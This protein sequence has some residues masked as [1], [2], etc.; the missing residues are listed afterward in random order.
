MSPDD[1]AAPPP[2][3]ILVV[4]PAV[5]AGALLTIPD[6]E[7]E[8]LRL[9]DGR[10]TVAEV[11]AGSGLGRGG[12]VRLAGAP[13]RRRRAAGGP[14]G[15]RGEGGGP[16]RAGGGR[17]VR[18]SGL[19]AR[20]RTPART[21]GRAPAEAPPRVAPPAPAPTVDGR[22]RS[23]GRLAVAAVALGA[24]VVAGAIWAQRQRGSAPPQ[25]RVE[26]PAPET[27]PPALA[28]TEPSPGTAYRDALLEVGVRQRG[29]RSRG[30]GGG[31]PPGHRDRS[32]GRGRLAGARR[33]LAGGR[34]SGPRP[35]RLRALPGRRTRWTARPAGP[36]AAR[37]LA[38][39]TP[40]GT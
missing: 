13:P 6:G 14:P 20:A 36:G 3:A 12:R 8:I 9:A 4:D 27:P 31:L 22:G 26:R 40:G 38:P 30:R 18:P 5:L 19:G 10:R 16:F 24:L 11:V 1:P 34:G 28:V 35:L 37:A 39:L 21:S 33:G 17:L 15:R 32:R 23:R 29:G 25:A 7:N 2:D